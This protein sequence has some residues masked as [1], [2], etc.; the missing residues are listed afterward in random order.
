MNTVSRAKIFHF[1][2]PPL[3]K[4]MYEKDGEE[5]I[6]LFQT[7]KAK[8]LVTTLDMAMPD[9]STYSGNV[10]WGEILKGVLPN[11]DVFFPSIEEVMY[12]V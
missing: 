2:Y 1:G 7:L 11:I 9:A 5:L 8:D 6:K 3:M 12:M 4:R 10:D